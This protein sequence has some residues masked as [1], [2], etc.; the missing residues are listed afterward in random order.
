V[1]V[2]ETEK[3]ALAPVLTDCEEGCE[4]M[5]GGVTDVTVSVALELVTEP[6]E[7]ETTQE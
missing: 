3:L 5:E 7:L 4:V 1:P 2:A 6:A